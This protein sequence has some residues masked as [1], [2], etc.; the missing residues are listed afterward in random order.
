MHG[1]IELRCPASIMKNVDAVIIGLGTNDVLGFSRWEVNEKPQYVVDSILRRAKCII[2]A[3]RELYPHATVYFNSILAQNS[4]S[5]RIVP[6]LNVTLKPAVISAGARFINIA[7]NRTSKLWYDSIHLSDEGLSHMLKQIEGQLLNDQKV[8]VR[9]KS[10]FESNGKY[11][12][13]FLLKKL[14]L[15]CLTIYSLAARQTEK[16]SQT[17]TVRT[18]ASVVKTSLASRAGTSEVRPIKAGT[19]EVRSTRA[20]TS[21]VRSTRA[22]TSEVR[23]IKAGTSEVRSI[24]AGT[25]EVRSIRAGTSE[26]RSIKAGTSEVRSIKAGTS[27]V[28][29]TRAGTSEVRSTRAGTSEVRSIKAGTSEVRSIK[30]GTS[31]VESSLFGGLCGGAGKA[32]K[33]PYDLDNVINAFKSMGK[34]DSSCTSSW[35]ELLSTLWY[36]KPSKTEF[37]NELRRLKYFCKTH[38][39]ELRSFFQQDNTQEMSTSNDVVSDSSNT[40]D[41][42]DEYEAA[43]SPVQDDYEAAPSPVQDEYEAAP[44]PVQDE[45]EAAPSPISDV[46]SLKSQVISDQVTC[47]GDED[48]VCM[49]S[50][51][52]WTC[53]DLVDTAVFTLSSVEWENVRSSVSNFRIRY[54]DWTDLFRRGLAES[55]PFCVFTFKN[56]HWNKTCTLK[57]VFHCTSLYD[58]VAKEFYVTY[59]GTVKHDTNEL[60][61]TRLKG[62]RRKNMQEKLVNVN[63]RTVYIDNIK[64]LSRDVYD[65]GNRTDAPGKCV[66]KRARYQARKIDVPSDNENTSYHHP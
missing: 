26:V 18:Y 41:Q 34:F 45:Y 17:A 38:N 10:E 16:T 25:S 22:G 55:N 66:L 9:I 30:A 48:E 12:Y 40:S 56:Q 15:L 54:S 43:P 37:R 47:S 51:D 11:I 39:V 32:K 63:P 64:A 58:E 31:G 19:S 13:I 44:S 52:F 29:S 6:L 28:R 3:A 50:G 59:E 33:L 23:S 2:G 35:Q 27:E 57:G 7:M 65:S 60:H 53:G 24:K 46:S 4:P 14:Y 49:E 61:G 21:E 5:G 36:R 20:G 62:D 1:D 8:Q 42:Q